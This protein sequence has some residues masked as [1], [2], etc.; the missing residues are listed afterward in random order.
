MFQSQILNQFLLAAC[1]FTFCLSNVSAQSIGPQSLALPAP[2]PVPQ[3]TPFAG[4][5]KIEVDAT[6]LD[7]HI[8]NVRETVPV[9]GGEDLVLLYP[10]WLPANH[11]D[12]GRAERI[13]GLTVTAN[14]ERLEWVRDTVN[15]FA[16]H[17]AIPDNTTSIDVSFQYLSNVDPTNGRIVMTPEMLN[18]QWNSVALYPAGHFARQIRFEPSVT[19]PDGWQIATALDTENSAD[20]TT[21]F[22]QVDFET[23][24][25]SPI[26]A[27]EHFKRIELNPGSEAAPVFLNIVADREDQLAIT[28]EQ[29]QIH[30]NLVA[31]ADKLYGSYHYDHYDFLL[32][33][34]DRLGGI[35]LE[36]HQS[37]ENSQEP[38]HFTAWDTNISD[39]DL[40]AHEYTHSWNGKFRRPADLWVANYGQPMRG[41]LLWVYEGQTQYWGIILS[42]RS[43]LLTQ[44]QALDSLART[45]AN[46][47]N[48][49]GRE[50]RTLQDTTNDPVI[51][52]RRA[53]PWRSWERSEDYYNEGLLM[54]LDADTL[55]RKLSRG[56]KSLDDFA[57]SFFGINNG[58]HVPVTYVF[59]DIVAGLNDI[60]PYDWKTFLRTRLDGHG[61]GAPLDG[62][63][64]GGYKLVY[65][66]TPSDI[67]AEWESS[68]LVTDLTYSI[69]AQIATEGVLKEIMWEGPA[70]KAGLT[71]GNQ[72]IAL[73]GITFDVADL[74]FAIQDAQQTGRSIELLIKDGEHYRTVAIEYTDGLRYPHLERIGKGQA[75]LD[76]ILAPVK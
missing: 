49:I 62:F 51:A 44:Q 8:F 42:A 34:T 11:A 53:H 66:D 56:K 76:D 72:I 36:H 14:G 7:R 16:F 31:Q 38:T 75:P 68:N 52:K 67:F 70:F 50:W 48:R 24:I 35:G 55:I 23:L 19:V 1:A 61:P 59:E 57:R 21:N 39:H 45:A 26:F 32:A 47:D 63:E 13:G 29:L 28:P 17:I 20:G 73:N 5:I 33:L 3:D 58:S 22:K 74:K 6:D 46:Y 15:I 2:I 12:Y 60:Q 4:V 71:I 30:R 25:D 10:Q 37:S 18:L 27:G 43:G 41:S 9:R 64:R 69:G 40:L 65:T 54:W